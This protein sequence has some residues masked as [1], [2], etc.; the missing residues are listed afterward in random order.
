MKRLREIS[1]LKD[2]CVFDCDVTED[3]LDE[4]QEALGE[5]GL[6]RNIFSALPGNVNRLLPRSHAGIMRYV[7]SPE[8]DAYSGD[9]HNMTHHDIA[10][11]RD[12]PYGEAGKNR[13]GLGVFVRHANGDHVMYSINDI[14]SPHHD[15]FI[16]K[17]HNNGI[18]YAGN[19]HKF[20]DEIDK[21]RLMSIGDL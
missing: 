2:S 5:P 7:V 1:P 14:N 19:R 18:R 15:A 17:M 11:E 21:D 8:G 13:P 20:N 12:I 6:G 10:T 16:K 9:A 4:L 3:A